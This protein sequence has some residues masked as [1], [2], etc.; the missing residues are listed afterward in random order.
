[1]KKYVVWFIAADGSRFYD[2]YT[3]RNSTEAMRLAQ[4]D[5]RY[6]ARV[7]QVIGCRRNAV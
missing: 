4:E 2:F 7:E 1:M 3:A 5:K 6:D